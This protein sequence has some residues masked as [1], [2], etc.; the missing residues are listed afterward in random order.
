MKKLLKERL[1]TSET[2]ILAHKK[3][4]YNYV[5]RG[6][7]TQSLLQKWLREV[8]DMY[9][10]VTHNGILFDVSIYGRYTTDEIVIK[11]YLTK[12]PTFITYEQALEAGLQEALKLISNTNGNNNSSN[13]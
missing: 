7:S 5:R 6:N 4:F 1:I 12:K 9:V 11:S 3:G 10:L 2:A 8:C 13:T